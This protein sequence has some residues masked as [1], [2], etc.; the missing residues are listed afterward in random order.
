MGK[1][2]SIH[3]GPAKCT[4]TGRR[5]AEGDLDAG[6]APQARHSG[7]PEP[8]RLSDVPMGCEHTQLMI[9]EKEKPIPQRHRSFLPCPIKSRA[10]TRFE[11]HSFL[12]LV[13]FSQSYNQMQPKSVD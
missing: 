10:W 7:A 1:Q 6:V 5:E 4:H 2:G 3:W 13:N 8:Q 9:Y 12:P 11:L